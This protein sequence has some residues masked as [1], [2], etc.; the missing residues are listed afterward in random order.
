VSC[1]TC[2]YEI[3]VLNTVG[4]PREFSVLCRKLRRAKIVPGGSGPRS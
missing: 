4:L 3:P 2:F 1:P